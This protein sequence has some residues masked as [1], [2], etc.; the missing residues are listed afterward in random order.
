M[1]IHLAQTSIHRTSS[2]NPLCSIVSVPKYRNSLKR[3]CANFLYH[4]PFIW[5]SPGEAFEQVVDVGLNVVY[6]RGEGVVVGGD[7]EEE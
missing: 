4:Q 1:C 3:N 6:Y 2:N 7:S 5:L